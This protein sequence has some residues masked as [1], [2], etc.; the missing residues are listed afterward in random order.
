MS[1]Q[2]LKKGIGN[3]WNMAA[4][5]YSGQNVG[6][7][8]GGGV[9]NP[10]IQS[11]YSKGTELMEGGVP[12]SL[13][14]QMLSTSQDDLWKGQHQT[15]AQFGGDWNSPMAMKKMASDQR[16]GTSNAYQNAFSM[17]P[18]F[19]QMGENMLTKAGGMQGNINTA[20]ATQDSQNAANSGALFRGITGKIA[21]GVTGG[22]M[23]KGMDK[24]QMMKLIMMGIGG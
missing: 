9:V 11:L 19:M 13:M 2:G 17:T 1:M 8:M 16:F 12:Q 4:G 20:M 5:N 21:G 10:I 23:G 3:M 14:N 22:V 24:D 7:T 18:Q 15:R 6:Q